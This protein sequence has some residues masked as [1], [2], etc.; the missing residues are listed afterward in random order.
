MIRI[1]LLLLVC[2]ALPVVPGQ[3]QPVCNDNTKNCRPTS[4][5]QQ[6]VLGMPFSW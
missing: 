1:S 4:I 3:S 6:T 5:S 2:L